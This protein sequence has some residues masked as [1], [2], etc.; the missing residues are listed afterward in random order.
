[1]GANN[2]TSTAGTARYGATLV[3]LTFNAHPDLVT[4]TFKKYTLT[5]MAGRNANTASTVRCERELVFP[6]NGA[7]RI[8]ATGEYFIMDTVAS[9]SG[10]TITDGL[11]W[12]APAGVKNSMLRSVSSSSVIYSYLTLDE[13]TNASVYGGSIVIATPN[14]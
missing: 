11:Y 14:S 13:S 10:Y 4:A 1:M 6:S 3:A 8:V 9:A 7:L 12:H 2:D 5:K